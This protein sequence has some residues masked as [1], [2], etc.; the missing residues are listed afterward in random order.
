MEYDKPYCDDCGGTDFDTICTDKSPEERL[1][2]ASKYFHPDP[3]SLA[4]PAVMIYSHYKAICKQCGRGY[5][6]TR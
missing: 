5:Q 3:V 4:V 1:Q 2:P 6:F